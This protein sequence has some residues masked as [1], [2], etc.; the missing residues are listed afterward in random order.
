MREE[1]EAEIARGGYRLNEHRIII[2]LSAFLGKKNALPG[3][4]A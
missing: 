2:C 1:Q 4:A 3:G